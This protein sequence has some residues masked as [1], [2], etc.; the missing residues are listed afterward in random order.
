MTVAERSE[1]WTV[2]S[3][4]QKATSFKIPATERY[5]L[6]VFMAFLWL[7][8]RFCM[9]SGLTL[10]VSFLNSSIQLYSCCR[11]EHSDNNS[12]VPRSVFR[13]F[14]YSPF[15]RHAFGS[16]HY[17]LF[18]LHVCTT[19]TSVP[20]HV[21]TT[22]MSVSLQSLYHYNVCTTKM[23]VPLHV[24]TTTCLYHQMSLPLHVCTTT[25]SVSLQSLYHY[26]VCTTTM[27]VP[28]HVC[29][30]TMSAPLNVFTTAYLY[31]YN[32]CITTKSV[33]LQCLYH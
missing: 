2:P 13:C 6:H 11:Q 25:M 9:L 33:P 28:L 23:S 14:I 29:T 18:F 17:L 32:V 31:H 10:H 4:T 24:C 12:T 27:S 30:T 21:C 3:P 8:L 16:I 26:N 20:L 15:S 7:S 19:T 5:H 1:S 22:T